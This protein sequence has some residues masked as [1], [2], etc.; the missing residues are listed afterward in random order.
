MHAYLIVSTNK[1]ETGSEVEKIQKNFKAELIKKPIVKIED[2]R[3][4]NSF[5]S[6]HLNKPTIIFIENVENATTEAL[7]AFLKN[8]EEPQENLFYVLTCESPYKVLPTIL[9]RCQI[10]KT[11]VD[12]KKFGSFE[13]ANKFIEMTPG[14]KIS[15]LSKIKSRDEAIDFLKNL[16]YDIHQL[17]ISSEKNIKIYAKYLKV[18]ENTLIRLKA[19]GNFVLQLT[20][21]SVNME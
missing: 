6:L 13:S 21:M 1:N 7:N 11:K 18:C 9:S 14:N 4:L 17:L 2:V 12:L 16:I 10:I 8:L 5:T 19:N 20:D 15:Y 3:S